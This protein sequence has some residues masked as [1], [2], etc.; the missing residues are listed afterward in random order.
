MSVADE[1]KEADLSEVLAN[2]PKNK[3]VS[4]PNKNTPSGVS[5]L[6]KG[7]D[8]KVTMLNRKLR[9]KPLRY[10]HKVLKKRKVYRAK[11]K[12]KS[13]YKRRKYY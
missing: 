11:R 10:G 8:G 13:K 12:F 9:G 4:I 2:M 5:F 1:V 6:Y 3:F 7:K